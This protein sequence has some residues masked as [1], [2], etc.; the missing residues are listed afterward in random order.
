M[1]MTPTVLV[2][3]SLAIFWATVFGCVYLPWATMSPKPSDIWRPMTAQQLRGRELYAENGCTY[4]HSQYVRTMDWGLGAER[5]SQAGDYH[6]DKPHL[7]GSERTGPDLSQAGGEHSDD[8]HHAHFVNPRFTS[9]R[10]LMPQFGFFSR[11]EIEDL[12]AYVQSLG[13]HDADQRMARQR[14]WQQQAIAAFEAGPDANIEWIH[15]TVPQVWRD[16]PNPYPATRASLARGER[17]YQDYCVGCH[18]P[19]GDGQGPAAKYLYPP[20]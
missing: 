7:L 15:S 9:P 1:K 16:M 3:G 10:S 8:W 11:R 18:G 19:V 2:L 13:G 17:V 12:T 14:Y 6:N 4:C 5:L 20:P